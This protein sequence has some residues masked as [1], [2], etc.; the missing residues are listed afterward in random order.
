MRT[1]TL[2]LTFL[3]FLPHA[4]AAKKKQ[5]YK[6]LDTTICPIAKIDFDDGDSFSCASEKIRVLG[7]DAPEVRHPKHGIQRDQEGGKTAAK[8]T[9]D[10]LTGAKRILIVRDGKD[11]YGRTLAHVLID[12]ELLGVKLIE[13]R[14][15]Y[16]N[17][18][19]FGDNGMP[20]FALQIIEAA[21]STRKPSFE[22]PYKWRRKNQKKNKS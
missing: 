12:G 18:N 15:A 17:V 3:L 1:A 4:H 16:E 10:A 11:P 5:D 22:E 8:F 13:S 20:E 19:H 7:V 14:L 2:A 21:K 9:R 6:K